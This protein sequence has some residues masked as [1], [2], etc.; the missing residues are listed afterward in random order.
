MGLPLTTQAGKLLPQ[1]LQVVSY[2]LIIYVQFFPGHFIL[3]PD[4]YFGGCFVNILT[5]I[6]IYLY[7][8]YGVPMPYNLTNALEHYL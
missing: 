4:V 2:S 6:S 3:Y 7:R 1:L 8:Y 5:A